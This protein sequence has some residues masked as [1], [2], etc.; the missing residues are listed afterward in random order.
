MLPLV[1]DCLGDNLG[2]LC[3]DGSKAISIFLFSEKL[4]EK[5]NGNIEIEKIENEKVFLNDGLR[6]LGVP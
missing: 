1:I 5:M 2:C 3:L 4:V 6:K